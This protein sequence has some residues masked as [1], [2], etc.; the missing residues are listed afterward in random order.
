MK[1]SLLQEKRFGGHFSP[2]NVTE[3]TLKHQYTNVLF[4]SNY[5]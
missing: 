1:C 2:Q 5:T 4:Y 3:K